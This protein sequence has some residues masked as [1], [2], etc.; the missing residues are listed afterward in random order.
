MKYRSRAISFREH[1]EKARKKNG[2]VKF[3]RISSKVSLGFVHILSI[4][5][6]SLDFFPLKY[7][8]IKYRSF[9][10]SI[11]LS[12]V[13]FASMMILEEYFIGSTS[14]CFSLTNEIDTNLNFKK[15]IGN[16]TRVGSELYSSDFFHRIYI[17]TFIQDG[18]KEKRNCVRY[19]RLLCQ[20]IYA[21]DSS[22]DSALLYIISM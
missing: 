11:M 21:T 5:T 20:R 3:Y 1:C 18:E 15:L 22:R 14:H 4:I 13:I 19:S 9:T 12:I 17:F 6:I 2:L 10:S 16:Q 8:S 7:F